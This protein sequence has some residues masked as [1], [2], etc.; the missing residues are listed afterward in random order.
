MREPLVHVLVI[1]WNGLE[2]LEACFASL[3][4]STH[5]RAQFILVDNASSDASVAFVEERF[6]ADARVSVLRCPGNLGWSGGNNFAIRHSL[7]AGAEYLFLLNND[8]AVAPDTVARLVQ[9]AEAMPE[10]GALAPKMRMFYEPDILNSVGLEC[11]RIGASW[12]R[13]VGRLDTGAWDTPRAVAGACGGAMFLR[14]SVL[15]HTGLLPEDFGIYLDDLDLCLRI[16]DAGFVVWTCPE[17]EVRHKFSATLGEGARAR[18]KYFLNT[19]NRFWLMLRNFPAGKLARVVPV[20]MLGEMRAIGRALLDRQAWQ[21][22]AHVRAWFAA[23]GYLRR[24]WAARRK[25]ARDGLSR[26]RFWPMILSRPLFCPGLL[27]P[28]DGWYPPREIAG[29]KLQPISR[30]AR[31]HVEAGRL[32][33]IHANCYPSL[34]PTA[35]MVSLD[36]APLC[37]L[38]TLDADE[39]EIEIPTPGWLEF[40][41]NTIYPAEE[42]GELTDF[43][44]WITFT[45][46]D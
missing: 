17:A 5:A 36:G 35:I 26:G 10:A 23:A 2:H 46:N 34:G 43:G 14:A 22:F 19:R 29:R 6:G 21:A 39:T 33:V 25:A 8:T 11:S 28:K 42:T 27:L 41:A 12:D 32:R 9:R 30:R 40:T 44:G 20:L 37:Q 7:A 4:E 15:A 1:N 13:G 38:S 18:H 45:R 16:W 3:L 24:A 31:A